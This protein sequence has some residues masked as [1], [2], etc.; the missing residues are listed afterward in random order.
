MDQ[1]VGRDSELETIATWLGMPTSVLLLEGEA[2]IGKTMLWRAGVEQARRHGMRV[3]T[4]VA[5]EPESRLSYVG[6]G[7][8]LGPIADEV[9]ADLPPPQRHALEAALLLRD[10]GERPPDELAVAVATLAALRAA[11][12]PLLVAIDDVQWLDRATSGALA[13]ALRRVAAADD[14]RILL[15]RRIGS[16]GGLAPAAEAQILQ[17]GGLSIGATR[18]IVALELDS[19][20]ARPALVRVHAAS[21]GNPLYALELA[22]V[23]L[24]TDHALTAERTPTLAELAQRRCSAMPESTREA[25]VLLAAAPDPTPALLS[26]ALGA[27]AVE[28]LRPAF[29]VGL[30]E[31]VGHRVRFSHPVLASAVHASTPEH[32]F[33]DAHLRLAET[34]PSVESRGHHLAL[35]TLEPRADVALAVE[36]AAATAQ[37]RG[38][39]ANAA[40]LFER[41]AELTPADDDAERGRRLVLAADAY[42]AGGDASRARSLLEDAAQLDGAARAE[43]L[44]RLGRILDETEGFDRSRS[45][46]EEALQTD[47]LALV[48]NVRRSMAL[49]ALF[50]DGETA[51]GDAVAG[52]EA[53]QRLGDARLLALALAMEAYVR[54]VLGDPGYREP[55]DRALVLEGDVEL[56]ELHSPSAVLADLG[57]LSLDLDA[58]RRGYEAVLRRAVDVADARTET[59]CAYGLGMVETLAGNWERG[60]EL[61]DRATELSEQVTLLGLPAVRL[62]ALLAASRGEIE[63]CRDLLDACYSTTRQMGDKVNLLGTLAIDGFLGLS[64]GS[65]PAAVEPLAEAWTIQAEL[66]IHEPGVTRFLVD[67]AEALARTEQADEGERA[68]AVFAHQVDE[69]GRTWGRPLV[70]RAEGLVLAARGDADGALARLEQAVADEHVLPMP[71]ERARTLLELGTIQRRTRR[72]RIARETLRRALAIFDELGAELWSGKTRTELA[73]IGGRAPSSGAL[74][75]TEERVAGLVAGGSTNKE[76]A[77]ELVVSV[78]TVEAALTSIYRKLGVRSRT[79]LTRVRLEQDKH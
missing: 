69:L 68:I 18:R 8:L 39:R 49:A 22:R 41:A 25:L 3:L 61:A 56:D 53:A 57:R 14:V 74:T 34:A 67:L 78:H 45:Q 36:R 32:L 44:W 73:R 29:E 75:P 71:L 19:T 2:G 13:Y 58:G 38:A 72:R 31:L 5:T 40:E 79:E 54:G 9:L 46:W 7:D 70:L 64:L 66:G 63:R 30:V 47:D 1:I 35:A 23:E 60:S 27:D 48:V 24:S 10:P 33:R 26:T 28:R 50:V 55:L 77:A 15:A 21:G 6:L 43:A 76:A 42:F 51:L 37:A 17:L 12:G 65:A 20:L 59:W 4:S 62:T 11:S 52:V 16:T